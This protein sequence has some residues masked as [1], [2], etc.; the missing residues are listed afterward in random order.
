M[1][2]GVGR[3]TDEGKLKP[4]RPGPNPKSLRPKRPIKKVI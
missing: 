3:K 2:L 4:K 1:L